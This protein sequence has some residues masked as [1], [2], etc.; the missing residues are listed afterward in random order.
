MFERLVQV[1]AHRFDDQR[2]EALHV[3]AA[4]SIPAVVCFGQGEGIVL[5]ALRIAGNGVGMAGHDQAAGAAAKTG[6]QVGLAGLIGN[7]QDAAFKPQ[8]AQPTG[9]QF[10][11]G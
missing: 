9:Q 2:E 7:R 3:A 6:E 4:Q 5:P 10:Y 8:I 1:A 11:Y